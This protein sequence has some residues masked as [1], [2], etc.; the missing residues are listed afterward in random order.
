MKQHYPVIIIGGGAAG[1][2]SACKCAEFLPKGS[3]LVLEQ[4]LKLLSK[5]KISGGGRC[6]VTHSCFDPKE[7]VRNYPRGNKELIG[8]FSKFQP[9]DTVA[10]FSERGLPL[11]TEQDGRMFPVTDDSQSVIDVILGEAEKKGVEIQ[12]GMKV[13]S[14]K[15]EKNLFEIECKSG[16]SF[17]SSLLLLATGGTPEGMLRAK[18]LGHSIIDPVPSLFTF[19]IPDSTLLDLSGISLQNVKISLPELKI[20]GKGPILLTHWGFSGPA[21]LKLSARAARELHNV[22]YR[23]SVAIDWMPEISYEDI[24]NIFEQMKKEKVGKS[25]DKEIFSEIPKNLWTRFLELSDIDP[26]RCWGEISAA[27]QSR[28][29]E[30]IKKD[31]YKINGKTT[32]KQ[33]FVTAGGVCR[34]EI[35]FRKMESKIISGL[36]F[37]GEILDIDGITGGFNFQAAWTG[38][39]IAGENM[40]AALNNLPKNKNPLQINQGE[41]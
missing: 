6:N 2:F 32:Y 36:Y 35:D 26:N 37:A 28:L 18:E 9:K 5:V 30:K 13:L 38:G 15:K 22:E 25:R 1:L 19:N 7:L 16:A 3:V 12:L 4:S 39:W 29:I 14:I 21:I 20:E 27:K 34:S 24:K 33:E 31:V 40:G 41:D 23:T 8:P 11:K 17:S 10:W